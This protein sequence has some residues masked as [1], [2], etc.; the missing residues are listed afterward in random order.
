[1]APTTFSCAATACEFVT[2]E[3][4]PE[5]AGQLLAF[6]DKHAHTQLQPLQ[7]AVGQVEQD[8]EPV[9]GVQN[10][11]AAVGYSHQLSHCT[12]ASIVTQSTQALDGAEAVNYEAE[13]NSPDA[14]QVVPPLPQGC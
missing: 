10:E 6:H 5:V 13:F 4:E 7:H 8:P 11:E 3:F 9:L 14:S 1:M 12:E 2:A